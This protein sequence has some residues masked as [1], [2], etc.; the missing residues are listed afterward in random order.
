M[1]K[2]MKKLSLDRE[3]IRQLVPSDLE[4]ANGATGSDFV[5][6]VACTKSG[7]ATCDS[8]SCQG[9]CAHACDTQSQPPNCLVA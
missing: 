9:S 1:K 8:C 4:M 7:A 3:T 5:T 6:C 2:R